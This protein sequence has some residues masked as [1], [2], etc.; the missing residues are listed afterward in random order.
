MAIATNATLASVTQGAS[1][2][3]WIAGATVVATDQ[4]TAM[5]GFDAITQLNLFLN[6]TAASGTT[7][8]LIVQIEKRLPDGTTYHQDWSFAQMTGTGKRVMSLVSGG[9][10]EEAQATGNL[11]AG[12]VNSVCFAGAMRINAVVGGTNPSFTFDLWCEALA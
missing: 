8:T 5:V 7:P 11:A 10:K 2:F 4:T 1:R 9:N 6:V 12:T 3:K